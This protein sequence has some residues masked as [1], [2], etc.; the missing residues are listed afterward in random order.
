MCSSGLC[1][2][3]LLHYLLWFGAGARSDPGLAQLKAVEVGAKPP[4]NTI[5]VAGAGLR[6]LP[7]L[8][9]VAQ[10]TPALL[11]LGVTLTRDFLAR[12]SPGVASPNATH[13]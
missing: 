8:V 13:Q 9:L 1:R 4:S 2:K 11:P 12:L 7:T 10:Q 3:K 6:F 5:E